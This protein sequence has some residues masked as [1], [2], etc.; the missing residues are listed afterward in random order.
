MVISLAASLALALLDAEVAATKGQSVKD[1]TKKNLL[2]QLGAYQKFCDRYLLQYFPCN[3]TQLCRFGQHL[4]KTFQSPDSVGNYLSGMR[5]ILALAG[6]E[7]PDVKDRQMQ[8]FTVGLK[9]IMNHSIKQAAPI[10]PQI[11]L[12]LSRVVNYQDRVEVISWTAT[13]GASIQY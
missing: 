13:L 4:S 2:S 5:T 10:T 11:L 7:I 6:M 1:S 3:N 9:H 8:M 12:R